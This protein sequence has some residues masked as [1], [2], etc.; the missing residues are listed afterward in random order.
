[1]LSC[2]RCNASF[3]RSKAKTVSE[4][5]RIKALCPECGEFVKFL[6]FREKET[7]ELGELMLEHMYIADDTKNISVYT[8]YR[9]IDITAQV[10]KTTDGYAV[11]NYF[12]MSRRLDPVSPDTAINIADIICKCINEEFGMDTQI[13]RDRIIEILTRDKAEALPFLARACK[14]AKEAIGC[15]EVPEAA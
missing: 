14:L 13:I 4:G 6:P 9:H 10:E 7:I 5:T 1:M 8:A 2:K 3:Y 11:R 15:H 12:D